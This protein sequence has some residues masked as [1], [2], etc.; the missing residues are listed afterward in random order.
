MKPWFRAATLVVASA[1]PG[2]ADATPGAVLKQESFDLSE[3]AEVIATLRAACDGC[4]W[5]HAGHEAAALRMEVDGRYSQHVFLTRGSKTSEYR[6]LLG[7]FPAGHHSLTLTRDPSASSPFATKASVSSVSFHPITAAQPEYDA[8]ALAPILF[9]RPNTIGHF[10]DTP[11]VMWYETDQTERGSRIRYS[12]IFSNEDGGTAAD[13]LLATWGRLTDIEYVYGIEFDR[14][15]KVLEETFQGKD[16]EIVP[17]RGRR[18]G[19]HPLLYVVTDNNMVKDVGTTEQRHAPAPIPF[20]LRDASREKVMDE[21]P[22]TYVITAQEARREGRVVTSP[23]PGSK[24]IFDPSRYAVVELCT[25]AEDTTFATFTFAIGISEG[26]GAPRFYDSSV[27]VKEFRISRSPDNFPN[28]CFRGAVALPPGTKAA[29]VT[30]LQ[31]RAHTRPPRKG[32][33]PPASPSGPARLRRVNKIFLM[34]SADLPEPSL[35]SWT[36]D[37]ALVPDDQP[38]TLDL[39]GAA[40]KK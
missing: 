39:R 40:K 25:A 19:R 12:V 8:I 33:A 27:G 1:S 30:S 18:E 35:F 24:Q 26:K 32:E 17:F 31:V 22:W 2:W 5:A 10:T 37:A 3:N 36:G 13:R 14:A 6:V 38:V 23:T 29:Q 7:S 20:D 16:H 15:G 4:D 34:S 28:S 9:A 11:L 21:N